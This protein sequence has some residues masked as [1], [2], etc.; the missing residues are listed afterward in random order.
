MCGIFG[1]VVPVED[2]VNTTNIEK[3][4]RKLFVLSESRGK[5]ASGLIVSVG[6][7][8]HILKVPHKGTTLIRS[9]QFRNL[10]NI[11]LSSK[12]KNYPLLIMGHTRLATNGPETDNAN[13]QPLA[14]KHAAI[15]HNGIIVNDDYLWKRFPKL[16]RRLRVDTEILLALYEEY[17]N[18]GYSPAE[19]LQLIY[20][21][22]EGAASI[23]ITETAHS[24]LLL[25]TNTGSLYWAK[26]NQ[27]FVFASERYTLARLGVA[28]VV[29]AAA[30]SGLVVDAE[31]LSVS[32]FN[33]RGRTAMTPCEKTFSRPFIK[34]SLIKHVYVA[35]D[36]FCSSLPALRKHAPDYDAISR[37]RRCTKCIMPETM[38]LIT[39]DVKG[40][41]NFCN[42]YKKARPAGEKALETYISRCRLSSDKPNCIVAL[43]GGRDSSYGLH[44]VK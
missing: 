23:A 33:L 28:P 12:T 20:K 10:M 25:A 27:L 35:S 22:I 8:T 1:L 31:T 6:N 3:T 37:I 39:F 42:T 11:V 41:C 16:R 18:H 34:H 30:L 9:R 26:T 17:K 7:N 5:E 15:I 13:N 38:P 24:C 14:G 44:Y 2:A 32:C 43:S 36:M 4:V 19:T 40:V 29:P 21:H